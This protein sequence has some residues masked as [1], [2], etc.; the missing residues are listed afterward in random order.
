MS[1]LEDH[2]AATS[3]AQLAGA[4]LLEVRAKAERDGVTG[5]QAKDLGDQAAQHALADALSARFPGDA[6]LSEEAADD[7]ARL[8]ADRVWI[9]DPL[10]G[11]R[12]FSEPGRDD[13]AVHVA[14]WA[15]GEL[16]AGAVCLPARATTYS[17]A[18]PLSVAPEPD[19]GP[20]RLAVSRSRPP[21]F[22]GRLGEQLGARLVPMGSAGVKAMSVVSGGCDAYV[23]AG[24]QFEWDSAAPV[25]VARAHGLHTSRVD[26]SKL[27]YNNRDPWLPDLLVCHPAIADH[28]LTT[29]ASNL[30]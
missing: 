12:E 29:L 4:R 23:H 30:T 14:L 20:L 15:G 18:A 10:D 1:P 9:I 26:G 11:T 6:V 27:R 17:T 16:V 3:L 7:H 2:L 21:E 19:G 5:S 8:D 22:V 13:W 25:A 24:G 28:L